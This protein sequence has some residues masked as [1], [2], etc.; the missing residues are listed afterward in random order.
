MKSTEI[1]HFK[2]PKTVKDDWMLGLTI[3]EVY[4]SIF[5]ITEG[6]NNS[7]VSRF[8]DSKK[9]DVS[10]EKVT[11]EIERDLDVSDIAA[12]H[13]QNETIAPFIIEEFREKMSKD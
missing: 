6:N 7:E 4:H 11:D 12:T 9:G 2:Q 13:L 8:P 10:Y 1:F 3:F 5:I